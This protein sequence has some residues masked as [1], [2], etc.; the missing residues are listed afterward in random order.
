[1]NKTCLTMQES[2]AD[3]L[4]GAL[5]ETHKQAVEKHL[6]GCP[7]CRAYMQALQEQEQALAALG[8]QIA[9]GMTERQERVI[10][11]VDRAFSHDSKG[12]R[13]RSCYWRWA[14]AAVLILGSGIA[15]GRFTAPRPVDAERLKAEIQRAVL[16]D[17]DRRV[18]SAVAAASDRTTEDLRVMAVQLAS[19]SR[20]MME[21][22]MAELIQLVENARRTDR[23]RVADALTHIELSR[24]DDRNQIAASLR[25]L[26]TPAVELSSPAPKTPIPTNN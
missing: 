17:V 18:N 20:A 13:G 12:E 5:D 7:D 16:A 8:E 4:L 23:Q 22:R 1:M 19:G 3:Y 11:A 15:I 25:S 21:T 26:A 6:E 14:V 24:L 2:V 10:Q 9:A